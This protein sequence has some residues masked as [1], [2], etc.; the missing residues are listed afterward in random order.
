MNPELEVL[1]K[2][3]DAV[4]EVRAGDQADRFE[5]EF[6]ARIEEVRSRQ[7]NLSR[8]RLLRAVDFAHRK[9]I[10]SQRKPPALPPQA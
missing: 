2:A 7:P 3:L 9:W 4:I 5:A 10:L 1:V 6:E 8:E